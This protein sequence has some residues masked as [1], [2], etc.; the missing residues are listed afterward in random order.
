M[1]IRGSIALVTGAN[2]GIGRAFVE[3][4][5]IGDATRIYAAARNV[6]SLE[7]LA[8]GDPQRIVPIPLDITDL[9]QVGD[10]AKRCGDVNLLINNAGIALF[11]GVIA[12]DNLDAARTEM[13]VNYFGTLAMCRAFAP[14]LAASGGGVVVNMLTVGSVVNL[15]MVASYCASKAA[16][17]SMTQAV[18]AE[19]SA[20]GTHVVGVYPGPVDTDM[21]AGVDMPKSTPLEIAEAALDAVTK[22]LEDVYPGDMA[23]SVRDGMVSDPKKL[24]KE[25]AT[26]LP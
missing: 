2:R 7:N 15:P 16:A 17:H 24:E 20:Q 10:A 23:A 21:S 8:A 14:I 4:L 18:R 1:E 11:A 13:E 22:G 6:G 9:D 3:A 5:Q 12:A 26:L 25:F 19:L